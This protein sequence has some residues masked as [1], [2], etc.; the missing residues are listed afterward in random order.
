MQCTQTRAL[1]DK[2]TLITIPSCKYQLSGTSEN[3][4]L[5]W[6]HFERSQRTKMAKIY[7][8]KICTMALYTSKYYKNHTSCTS[9]TWQAII[10]KIFKDVTWHFFSRCC[11]FLQNSFKCQSWTQIYCFYASIKK[12]GASFIQ[13]CVEPVLHLSLWSFLKYACVWFIRTPFCPEMYVCEFYKSQVILKL[14]AAER[15]QIS[16][17]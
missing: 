12:S 4:K 3:R 17:L 5:K 8:Y 13:C 16:T 2:C 11:Y 14:C 7:M 10:N 6:R 9:P 1:I 15:F